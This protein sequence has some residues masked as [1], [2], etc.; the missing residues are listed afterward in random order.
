[1]SRQIL[2]VWQ[3]GPERKMGPRKPLRHRI[4]IFY[5]MPLGD[6]DPSINLP[7]DLSSTPIYGRLRSAV[8][9]FNSQGHIIK[10]RDDCQ[11]GCQ[12]E[13]GI[14]AYTPTLQIY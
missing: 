8:D 10:T 3:K 5:F 13:Q 7:A 11:N 6:S 2:T 9:I 12:Q 14:K 4:I 1:M